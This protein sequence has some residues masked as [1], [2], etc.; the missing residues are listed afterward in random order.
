M[1]IPVVLILLGGGIYMS[2]FEKVIRVSCGLWEQRNSGSRILQ[3][4]GKVWKIGTAP[5]RKC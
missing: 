3:I 2:S 5:G 1:G 4:V